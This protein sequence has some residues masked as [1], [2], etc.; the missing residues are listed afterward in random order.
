MVAGRGSRIVYDTDGDTVGDYAEITSNAGRVVELGFGLDADGASSESVSREP[1]A[2]DRCR[3]VFIILDSIPYHLVQEAY[4][5]GRFRHFHP[6]SRVI[7]PFPVMTDLCLNELFGISPA[8]AVE[9]EYFDGERLRDGWFAYAESDNSRWLSKVD[10]HVPFDQHGHVYMDAANW[11]DHELA[12]IEDALAKGD[13]GETIG[14]VVSTSA[15]GVGL[16]RDG[17][18][19]GLV[20][21]DRFCQALM[22][23]FRGDIEITLM[24]DHGHNLRVS[25]RLDLRG[26]AEALGYRVGSTLERV[27]DVVIPEFGLVSCAAAYTKTPA[28][29]SRDLAAIE[30]VEL[31]AFRRGDGDIGVVDRDGEAVVSVLGES[32]VPDGALAFRYK[33]LHG[34]PLRLAGVIDAEGIVADA[35]LREAL[36]DA[37]YPDA[38][39]R[40]HRAFNGLVTHTPQV[41]ISLED[42]WFAGSPLMSQFL[43]A[44]AIHGNLNENN[45]FAFVMSTASS[46]PATMRMDEL[47]GH[48]KQ[49]RIFY[50]DAG[51]DGDLVSGPGNGLPV[52]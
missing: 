2:T 10:V 17:H 22:H 11:F 4:D 46:L 36:A 31:V 26:A 5:G 52:K 33:V 19:A 24:S 14:Y 34:D 7:A 25:R 39:Y 38:L 3:R 44:K 16:G 43:L 32:S 21:L 28:R 51:V 1:G 47:L 6:P 9:T 27:G 13:C 15:L 18:A 23:R 35:D 48:L 42:G 41:L 30:G 37:Y 50:S 20:T 45:S 12:L 29:F 40:L 49:R 8:T